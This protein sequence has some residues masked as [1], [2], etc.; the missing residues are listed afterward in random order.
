[1]GTVTVRT[2]ATT[3]TSRTRPSIHSIRASPAPTTACRKA[4]STDAPP[5]CPR[6]ARPDPPDVDHRHPDDVH[7][8]VVHARL[9]ERDPLAGPRAE[10]RRRR[11]QLAD[12]APDLALR[13]D[14]DGPV[15]GRHRRVAATQSDRR[16]GFGRPERGWLRELRQ[17]LVRLLADADRL[18]P[19]PQPLH[20]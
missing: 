1:M 2:R 17:L 4:A 13:R 14:A 6:R 15:C 8:L 16:D 18:H 3:G 12:L 11:R 5:A 20:L 19:G 10:C 9:R 7:A